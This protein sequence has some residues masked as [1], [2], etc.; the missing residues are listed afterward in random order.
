MKGS[1]KIDSKKYYVV[2]VNPR[3]HQNLIVVAVFD[4]E[5]NARSESSHLTQE[6]VSASLKPF[7]YD[8]FLTLSGEEILQAPFKSVSF[9]LL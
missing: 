3:S 7:D 5:W 4:D 8:L 1:E 2:R 9:E 6:A